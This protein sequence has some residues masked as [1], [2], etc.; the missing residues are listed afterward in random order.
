MKTSKL[1][2]K[3]II[4]LI[5]NIWYVAVVSNKEYY[6]TNNLHL[7]C[8]CCLRKNTPSVIILADSVKVSSFRPK[9]TRK[10]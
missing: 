10:K 9:F 6:Y 2:I 7:I 4:I 5:T 8:G 3:N 1:P